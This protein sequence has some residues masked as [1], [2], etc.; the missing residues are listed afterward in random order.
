MF[1]HKIEIILTVLKHTLSDRLP[2]IAQSVRT[3][4]PQVLAKNC[5]KLLEKP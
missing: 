4:Y 1:T 3:A 5:K 2:P